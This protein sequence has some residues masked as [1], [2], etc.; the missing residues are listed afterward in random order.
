MA[1]A[2]GEC[3]ADANRNDDRGVEALSSWLTFLLM[4]LLILTAIFLIISL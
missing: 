2:P 4:T 3:A 1:D